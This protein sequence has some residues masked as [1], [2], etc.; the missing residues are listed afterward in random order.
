MPVEF[1]R[2]SGKAAERA[3]RSGIGV[4]D[5]GGDLAAL[6]QPEFGRGPVCQRSK[7]G[8]HCTCT[9]RQAGAVGQI[10]QPYLR[11]EVVLPGRRFFRQI[12]PLAGECALRT[13]DR[14]RGAPGEVVGEVEDQR[15]PSP[16]RGQMPLEPHQ[17][18][19]RHLRRHH[20][21]HTVQ[22]AVAG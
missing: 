1:G 21:A 20:S 15:G 10:R 6:R 11:K 3:E 14:A 18:G 19:R 17:L 22:H 9:I 8:A 2:F 12:C 16:R 5:A 13:A 7:V 4:D